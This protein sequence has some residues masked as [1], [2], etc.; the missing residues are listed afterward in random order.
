MGSAA[1]W[2]DWLSHIETTG[3]RFALPCNPIAGMYNTLSMTNPAMSKQ[4]EIKR[5]E[6]LPTY[7]YEKAHLQHKHREEHVC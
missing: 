2:A 1:A 4:K 7:C 5:N 3:E 6:K